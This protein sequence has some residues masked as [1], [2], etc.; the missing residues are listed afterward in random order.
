MGMDDEERK[1]KTHETFN[2]PV[3]FAHPLNNVRDMEIIDA[4]FPTPVDEGGINN[5]MVRKEVVDRL[6]PREFAIEMINLYYDRGAWEW[7]NH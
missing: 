2:P 3:E 4:Y 5:T 1:T 6:P 7:V